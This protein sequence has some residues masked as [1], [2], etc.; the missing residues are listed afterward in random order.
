MKKISIVLVIFPLCMT[1]VL[2]K[3]SATSSQ[4]ENRLYS[5]VSVLLLDQRA[6]STMDDVRAQSHAEY[7]I[8]L[9]KNNAAY[10]EQQPKQKHAASNSVQPGKQ[11]LD[12]SAP[13]ANASQASLAVRP[14]NPVSL[15]QLRMLH[16]SLSTAIRNRS[17]ISSISDVP[18]AALNPSASG[19]QAVDQTSQIALRVAT[20]SAVH[21]SGAKN[22][23]KKKNFF[24]CCC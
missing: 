18:H 6:K 10:I 13:H 1:N 14:S 12:A 8:M 5:N 7:E 4:S 23:K 17:L 9:K 21:N 15:A 16:P 3:S 22:T 24:C 19:K 20:K 2:L 11:A